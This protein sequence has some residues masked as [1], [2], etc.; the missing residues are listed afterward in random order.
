MGAIQGDDRLYRDSGR[1]HIDQQKGDASL[2]FG[3]GVSTY[4]TENPIGVLAQGGPGFLTIDN[5]VIAIA[6]CTG[7]QGGQIRPCAWLG[8]ALAPPVA[9]IKD[10][11]QVM[12]LLLGSAK[13]DNHWRHHI[14]P[15]RDQPGGSRRRTLLL[16]NMLFHYTPA[17]AAILHRPVGGIPAAA[18]KYRLPALVIL[19]RQLLAKPHFVSNILGQLGFQEPA[20]LITKGKLLLAEMNIHASL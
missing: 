1:V 20:Y 19:L 4:Q 7:L 15:K 13:L 8:V 5:I 17:G 16:E 9:T 12:G 11:R 2:W 3:C 18:V 14:D 10:A 6:H